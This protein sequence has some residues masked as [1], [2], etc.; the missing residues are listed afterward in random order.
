MSF[1]MT[2]T[3][4][5]RSIGGRSSVIVPDSTFIKQIKGMSH[6]ESLGMVKEA[7][8]AD[9]RHVR[10][11]VGYV[12]PDL[13]VA[14]YLHGVNYQISRFQ[15]HHLTMLNAINIGKYGQ[16]VNIQSSRGSAKTTCLVIWFP[17]WRLVYREFDLSVGIHPEDFILITGRNLDAA[18]DRLTSIRQLVEGNWRLRADFGE[19]QGDVWSKTEFQTSKGSLVRP[20]G[21]LQ[22]PRG[23][24][25][26]GVRP[27]L[28]L[29]DDIEDPKR[30]LNPKL[31]QED[32]DWLMTDWLF[33]SDLGELVTK[34]LLVDTNKHPESISE[35]LRTTP[36]WT[37]Y[38]FQA[39]PFPED[40]YHPT[41]EHL[42]REWEG[43]YADMTIDEEK[44]IE[45][46]SAY[47]HEN[48][49]EMVS[50]VRELWNEK[51]PYIKV[52][53]L[54][55]E[56]GYHFVMREL[57]NV[58]NDPSMSLFKMDNAKRFGVV[59]DGLMRDD[60]RLV[61]W[62]ELA[63][64][65]TYLDTMGGRD[66]KENSFA[67]AVCIAFEPLPGGVSNNPDSLAGVN[68][69]IVSAWMDRVA[70]SQQLENAMLLHQ[71]TEG[72]LIEGRPASNFVVE[73]RP[74]KEGTIKES[75]DRAFR[76]LSDRLGFRG[77]IQYHQQ[78]QNKE[79]RISTLEP[80]I[81]NGWLLFN[82]RDLPREFWLQFRQF[83]TADHNDAP[84]AVQGALRQ[85]VMRTA[86]DRH[87]DEIRKQ[88]ASSTVNI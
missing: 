57:Q 6:E 29:A 34:F 60:G 48:Q 77:R 4:S 17:L 70:L 80:A 61:A 49:T 13:F 22:S 39:I 56:R 37:S 30:C 46:A 26:G 25:Y 58:A 84:D 42:W 27:T 35:R 8:P 81:Y 76:A 18:I 3:V 38:R 69:Y 65:T 16:K 2:G 23:A 63:G 21:R 44:R 10:A 73:E 83:P 75:T 52:R 31:R 41:S 71:R 47:Y 33:A 78:H 62:H 14:M 11:H 28:Q 82:E 87:V 74:D 5:R 50:G 54:I 88:Y 12:H 79:D 24:L 43:V 40:L 45:M 59:R 7:A 68:A 85:K 55:V 1:R 20:L 64:F 36:G 15:P 51:L 32:W 66:A 86:R 9:F 67:C 19:M 53:E 72:L